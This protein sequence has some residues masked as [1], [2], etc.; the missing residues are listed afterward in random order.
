MP[1]TPP[2]P[3]GILEPWIGKGKT[4]KDVPDDIADA[5]T[6]RVTLSSTGLEHL[7]PSVVGCTIQQLVSHELPKRSHATTIFNP[8]SRYHPNQPTTTLSVLLKCSDWCIPPQATLDGLRDVSGQA[9]LDGCNSI[10]VWDMKDAIYAPLSVIGL[11]AFLL[12][13]STSQ[14]K[15]KL[16]LQWLNSAAVDTS[17][18]ERAISA[19]GRVQWQGKLPAI[20]DW[21]D[22]S[23]APEFLSNSYLS[24]SHVNA[25]LY[26]VRERVSRT[27]AISST[28]LISSTDLADRLSHTDTTYPKN[29]IFEAQTFGNQFSSEPQRYQLLTVAY[30]P[31]NHW[32]AMRLDL[33]G[34]NISGSWGDSLGWKQ[35]KKLVKGIGI[36]LDYH[37]PLRRYTFSD[38]L[39]CA[40][41]TDSFSCGIVA[42]NALKHNLFGDPLWTAQ[43]AA[44]LRIKEFCD[45]MD[46]EYPCPN[47]QPSLA[48][49]SS[50][51]TLISAVPLEIPRPV[52]GLL[53][54]TPSTQD[55]RSVHPFFGAP[56]QPPKRK[57]SPTNETSSKPTKAPRLVAPKPTK[58]NDNP[59]SKSSGPKNTLTGRSRST[60]AKRDINEQVANGTFVRSDTKWEAYLTK[61]RG[62]D[63]DVEVNERDI[64][65]I[66]KARHSQCA[67]WITQDEPYNIW[68]FKKHLLTCKGK[69][70]SRPAGNT[71]TLIAM[72][73][74]SFIPT[75]DAEPSMVA[76]QSTSPS[77]KP[78]DIET[79]PCPGLS[80]EDDPRIP[81]YFSRTTQPSAGGVKANIL[82]Q[83]MFGVASTRDLDEN[84]SKALA[85]R[86][87]ATHRWRLDLVNITAL[88]TSLS[89]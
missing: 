56:R 46:S 73:A 29:S 77:K 34:K 38:D 43:S 3:L 72:D 51:R 68:K 62:L 71:R 87:Q 22:V 64:T 88:S 18:K 86:Q 58:V 50:E 30:S 9:I 23:R 78:A 49:T 39:P 12:V 54:P 20:S 37:V 47:I 24:T 66:R 27:S 33:R 2:D 10:K 83:S 57:P 52:Q 17:L 7:L 28:T 75:L 82:A 45:I 5:V 53:V 25:M 14:A 8:R 79:W 60:L 36:W 42:V 32:A 70:S 41:Q 4:Y 13:A 40:V 63:P 21:L 74:V 55:K 48:E 44:K 31:P 81:Q 15:W 85:L 65:E 59:T 19:M 80:Q 84:Q 1:P 89:P 26:L 76:A 61:L 69:A 16:A 6:A 35:P 11:W 67:Q